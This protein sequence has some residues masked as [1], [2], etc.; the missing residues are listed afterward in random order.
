MGEGDVP[1]LLRLVCDSNELLF[2]LFFGVL[3]GAEA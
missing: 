1:R 2:N 3:T